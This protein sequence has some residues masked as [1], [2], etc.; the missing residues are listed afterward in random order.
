MSRTWHYILQTMP[1]DPNNIN[2]L[3]TQSHV[4]CSSRVKAKRRLA[5][6]EEGR[7]QSRDRGEP[8]RLDAQQDLDDQTRAAVSA[9]IETPTTSPRPISAG[10]NERLRTGGPGSPASARRR[11]ARAARL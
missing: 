7:A 6:G 5:E 4:Y 9:A 11:F 10:A 2:A 1:T 3:Q 8:G